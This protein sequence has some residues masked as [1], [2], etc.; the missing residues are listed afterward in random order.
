MLSIMFQ[1]CWVSL[2]LLWQ[3]MRAPV[4]AESMKF[5]W[6]SVAQ[7][8]SECPWALGLRS[9]RDWCVCG[10][11]ASWGR[12]SHLWRREK[13]A[14][15][16]TGGHPCTRAH[17]HT[18]THRHTHCFKKNIYFL[19]YLFDFFLRFTWS[20]RPSKVTWNVTTSYPISQCFRWGGK[21]ILKS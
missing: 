15:G 19:L 16:T 10:E 8:F 2:Q 20:K 4:H 9:S 3:W 11:G 6:H 14:N 17:A 1:K 13:S 12:R 5:I 7:V 21:W 18:H